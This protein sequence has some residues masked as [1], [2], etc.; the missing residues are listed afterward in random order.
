MENLK[1]NE[2]ILKHFQQPVRINGAIVVSRYGV[3]EAK[4]NFYTDWQWTKKLLDKLRNSGKYC[5]IRLYSNFNEEWEIEVTPHEVLIEGQE[6]THKR[7]I[8]I[9]S[10]NLEFCVAEAYYKLEC[11]KITEFYSNLKRIKS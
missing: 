6:D 10:E 2:E 7:L 4:P 9:V 11:E 5:C 8:V 1:K 3:M